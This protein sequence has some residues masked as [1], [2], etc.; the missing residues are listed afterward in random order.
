MAAVGGEYWFFTGRVGAR[1]GFR[2]NTVADTY[3]A[4]SAGITA[5]TPWSLFVDAQ[6]TEPSGARK[7]DWSIA[8]R[9]TF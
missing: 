7:R 9:L 1:S 3:H 4:V 6:L 8:A 2:W 5:R